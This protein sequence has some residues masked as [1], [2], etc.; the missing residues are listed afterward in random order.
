MS[1]ETILW[2][3]SWIKIEQFY[4]TKYQIGFEQNCLSFKEYILVHNV[5]FFFVRI[6]YPS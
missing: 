4:I 3:D 5:G 1:V 6:N 2:L